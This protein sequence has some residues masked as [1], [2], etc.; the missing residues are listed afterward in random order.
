ML[1]GK[2]RLGHEA[3]AGS[4]LAGSPNAANQLSERN[5]QIV[6]DLIA[7]AEARGHSILELAFSWLLA[8]PIVA[9]VIAGATRPEQVHTNAAAATWHLTASELAAINGIVGSHN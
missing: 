5:L 3:P 4:R 1:T 7:F 8:R 9:S 2:Y 6:E